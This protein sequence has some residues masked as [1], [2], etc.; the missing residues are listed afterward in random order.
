MPYQP[1]Y[2]HRLPA[3]FYCRTDVVQV[4]KDLL[5]KKLVTKFD[6]KPTTGII[7]EVEAYRAPDDRA[8]HAFGN[9]RTKR[10]EI[11]FQEGGRAYIYLCYG[12]HHL[13]NV[14]TAPEGMAHAVLVR[15]IEPL[16]G[17]ETMFQRRGIKPGAKG[18]IPTKLTTGPGALAQ[19]LGLHTH[20]TGH[21][22]IHPDSEIWIED[23]GVIVSENT[24][25]AGP[26]IGVDYAG[27]CAAWE[28][29]FWLRDSRFVSKGNSSYDSKS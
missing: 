2:S 24:I 4:A 21:S 6:N 18:I 13:F 15:G 9:R 27:E 29:R 17:I 11:M 3:S 7:T 1:E 28:W 22:L 8:C 20:Q 12:I 16:E 23:R 25:D 14:V 5:G 19:A 26:R 10:T